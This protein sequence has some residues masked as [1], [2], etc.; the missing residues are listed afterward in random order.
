MLA[1]PGVA[2]FFEN[3]RICGQKPEILTAGRR[4]HGGEKFACSA[5]DSFLGK[6]NLK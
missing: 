1:A 4:G 3:L 5:F 2:L 6:Q